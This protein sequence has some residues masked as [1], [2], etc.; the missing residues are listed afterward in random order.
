MDVSDGLLAD[1]GHMCNCSNL[2]AFV[3]SSK[4]PLSKPAKIV[5]ES[6]P[7]KE[8]KIL[9]DEMITAGDDYELILSIS[10]DKCEDV[11]FSAQTH[12][13]EIHPFGHM[14]FRSKDTEEAT[15]NVVTVVNENGEKQKFN[16]VGYEHSW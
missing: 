16:R 14:G 10:P 2:L 7:P 13:F 3:D 12:N 4:I 15:T 8:R 11:E 1:L 5:L 6:L 9:F